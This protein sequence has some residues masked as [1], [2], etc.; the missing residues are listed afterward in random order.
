MAV[1][2]A[3]RCTPDEC[4]TANGCVY[5][6]ITCD[7]GDACTTNSCTDVAGIGCIFPPVVCGAGTS[8]DP[9]SGLCED[10]CDG[11]VCEPL[12]ECHGPG[13][14][15]ADAA[16]LP[17]CSES[18]PLDDGTFCQGSGDGGQCVIPACKDAKADE[19]CY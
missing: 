4:D 18:L 2:V 19:E 14:C 17:S 8:C 1:T 6:A 10:P 15:S 16:G 7:D 5:S 13:S 11:V 12:D 3:A 9:G